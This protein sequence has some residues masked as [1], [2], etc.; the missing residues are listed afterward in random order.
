MEI[1]KKE[2]TKELI[3]FLLTGVLCALV[4][5]IFCKLFLNICKGL[6][7][8]P[9]IIISTAVGFIFGVILNYLLSTFWVF[10]N[11]QKKDEEKK[12]A[13]FITLFVLFSFVGLVLSVLMMALCQYLVKLF[14][15]LNISDS[16]FSSIFKSNFLLNATF[17]AYFISFCL[18][19]L[20]GLIWNYFTRKFILYKS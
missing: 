9:A 5:F 16:D 2:T 18:K 19:T 8:Y 14:W 7:E 10:K 4:D 15:G 1:I 13:K 20:I 6:G 3:R 17:W 11:S 12:S